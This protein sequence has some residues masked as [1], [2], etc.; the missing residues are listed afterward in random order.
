MSL[1][2]NLAVVVKKYILTFDFNCY[3]SDDINIPIMYNYNDVRN[4]LLMLIS[5]FIFNIK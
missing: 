1:T 3:N 5:F 4:I 2:K